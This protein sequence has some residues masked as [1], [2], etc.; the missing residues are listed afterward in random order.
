MRA[1]FL[2]YHR[3]LLDVKFWQETQQRIREGHIQDFFPYPEQLR[4]S[5]RFANMDGTPGR[6]A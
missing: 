5:R 6:A 4:F 3:D 1:A 2:K